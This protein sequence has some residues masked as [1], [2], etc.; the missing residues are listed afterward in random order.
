MKWLVCFGIWCVA[1]GERHE[2]VAISQTGHETRLTY[3][4][5]I[6]RG[7]LASI[8]PMA[9]DC[10]LS[11]AVLLAKMEHPEAWS[12]S[13]RSHAHH[14][15]ATVTN[16]RGRFQLAIPRGLPRGR[17][18]A[19]SKIAPGQIV[20]VFKSITAREIFRRKPRVRMNCGRCCS[21]NTPRSWR[22]VVYRSLQLHFVYSRPFPVTR[23]AGRWTFSP[24]LSLTTPNPS[25]EILR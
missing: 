24:A 25:L 7:G 14:L 11:C 12:C 2:K 23:K 1:R 15:P 8:S 22:G 13:S 19:H 20:R 4:V 17:C 16:C 5:A 10:C 6:V 3:L 9:S 21:S 18:S